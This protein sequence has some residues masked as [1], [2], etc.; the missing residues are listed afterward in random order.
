MADES[1]RTA[2]VTGAGG[3]GGIAAAICRAL[4]RDGWAVVATGHGPGG[5]ALVAELGE[6]GRFHWR[7]ADLADTAQIPALFDT[8]EQLAGSHV[9]ALV[10]AHA[11]SLRG[12]LLEVTPAEFDAH[13]AVNARGTLLLMQEFAR[14]WRGAH[15]SGRIV[16]FVSG[17]PLPGEIAYAASKG[18]IDW[19]TLTA[20]AELAPRGISVNAIDPGPTDTGWMTADV[21]ADIARRSPLGRTGQPQDAAELVAFL[22]SGRG[23]WITGQTLRS[24][25]GWSRLR[26]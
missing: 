7:D 5:D 15:G 26:R 19:L 3:P 11:R 20:A 16:S 21:A 10:A 13:M 23:G 12:G 8:A 18:A 22:C 4:L 1:V 9:D 6:T 14:R 17:P 24:D 25:G 2:L